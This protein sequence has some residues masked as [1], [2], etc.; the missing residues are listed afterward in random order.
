MVSGFI[1]IDPG[2][3]PVWAQLLQ[4]RLGGNSALS[5]F[6]PGFANFQ[7]DLVNPSM[8]EIFCGS[9]FIGGIPYLM[10]DV[11]AVDFNVNARSWSIG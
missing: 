8:A 5:G 7:I 1:N 6:I 2:T 3:V 4:L 11:D 10:G 9:I